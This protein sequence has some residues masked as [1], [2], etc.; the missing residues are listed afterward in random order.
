MVDKQKQSGLLRFFKRTDGTDRRGDAWENVISGLGRASYD[1]RLGGQMQTPLR[2][3]SR[4]QDEALFVGDDLA[5]TIATLP[6]KEMVRKWITITVDADKSD[7]VR[8][9]EIEEK[10]DVARKAAD[11]LETIE[12]QHH[13]FLSLLWSRVFGGCL[14]FLGVDDGGGDDPDSMATPLNEDNIREFKFL[15]T[16]DRWQVSVRKRYDDI[17]NPNFGEPELY[18]IVPDVR[19]GVGA[20][21]DLVVHESRFIRFDGVLTPHHRR[22]ENDGWSDGV[23]VAI[24]HLLRDYGMSWA[25]VAYLLAD[26]AV[27]IFKMS[28]LKD[29]LNSDSE[30]LI[31][32]RVQIIELCRSIG[33]VIPLDNEKEDFERKQSPVAGLPETLDRL[34]KRLATAARMPMTLLFGM[35][36]AGMNATGASDIRLFYDH[37]SSEQESTLR[38]KL[39][40]LLRIMWIAGNGPTAG[41]E[42][43]SWSFKFVPLWQ[44]SEKEEAEIRK[45]TADTDALYLEW[46]VL[47]EAEV[48]QSRFGGGEY[49]T[50]TML[51][52]KARDAADAEPSDGDL[53]K[54]IEAAKE[55]NLL[56]PN[57]MMPPVA[58][59]EPNPVSEPEGDADAE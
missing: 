57:P 17:G 7:E 41:K 20:G 44:M 35:S 38:P 19:T 52:Q 39:E 1:K 26:F 9:E 5:K 58:M 53:K 56:P 3:G 42:P 45:I 59:P 13:V 46:G 24:E 55:R 54:A 31:L 50:E 27:N 36:P 25:G 22:Q 29:A 28:G 12:A 4:I 16:F 10:A 15:K 40:R 6:A 2:R 47:T 23:F 21:R 30:N 18:T 48:T 49:S 11:F 8:T 43:E 51:D 34:D 37:I 33:R 32:N 14:L